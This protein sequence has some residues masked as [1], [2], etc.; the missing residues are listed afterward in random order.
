MVL[1]LVTV[2]HI[3]IAAHSLWAIRRYCV[4]Y[5]HAI[6]RLFHM[7]KLVLPQ[8]AAVFDPDHIWAVQ[9][10]HATQSIDQSAAKFYH[11]IHTASRVQL[12]YLTSDVCG[13]L[14][15]HIQKKPI[16]VIARRITFMVNAAKQVS[17]SAHRVIRWRAHDPYQ[18]DHKPV[19]VSATVKWNQCPS[20]DETLVQGAVVIRQP[21]PRSSL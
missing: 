8:D 14:P 21:H 7:V 10:K 9:E 4:C 17:L 13:R 12:C 19:E 11:V 20:T 3:V 2:V 18:G 15:D 5:H 16:Q 1:C 6:L